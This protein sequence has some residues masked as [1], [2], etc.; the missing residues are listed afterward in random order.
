MQTACTKV[1]LRFVSVAT[2]ENFHAA[3]VEDSCS[4]TTNGMT[5]ILSGIINNIQEEPFV[6]AAWLL[7]DE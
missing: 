7:V 2:G 6:Q 1:E 5:E 3:F 4:L